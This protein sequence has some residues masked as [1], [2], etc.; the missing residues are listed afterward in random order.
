MNNLKTKLP[1]N[2]DLNITRIGFG[3]WAIG[4]D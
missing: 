3:A 4:G 2:S 1:G